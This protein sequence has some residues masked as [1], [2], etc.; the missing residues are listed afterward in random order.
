M[1]RPVKI[2][3]KNARG[4]LKPNPREPLEK[5]LELQGYKL[6]AGVDE[7]GRGA[8][9]G[10]MVIAAVL[11]DVTDLPEGVD[12]SKVL[13]PETRV[14]VA[15]EI[16]RFAVSVAYA[17]VDSQ[18]IDDEGLHR[19]NRA[20]LIQAVKALQ[21]RPDYTVCDHFDLSDDIPH[22][23]IP[24]ADSLSVAVGAASILAKVRRDAWMSHLDEI[25]PGYGFAHHKGYGTAEHWTAV[26]ALG[27]CPE[28][29]RSFRGVGSYQPTLG[30]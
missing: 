12:D 22:L 17:V 23:A 8:I 1:A 4:A 16:E 15:A 28:H 6:I 14:L 7:V 30:E 26:R 24:R 25:H 3:P 2:P 9:A 29:R 20:A 10:P 18:V 11:L 27:L 19:L 13:E 21:P 5:V